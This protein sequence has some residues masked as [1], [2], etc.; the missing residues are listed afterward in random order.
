MK[1]ISQKILL[2]IAFKHSINREELILKKYDFY[3]K[4]IKD[5]EMNNIFKALKK[6]SQEHLK[7]IKD[8][9][10]KQNLQV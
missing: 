9:A 4:D 5:K 6:G 1:R 2:E 8:I 7:L 10:L 3:Y